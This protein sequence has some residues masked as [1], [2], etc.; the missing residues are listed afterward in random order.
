MHTD[1]Q[2]L[3]YFIYRLF[4]Q[5]QNDA[6]CPLIYYQFQNRVLVGIISGRNF[7][8]YEDNNDENVIDLHEDIYSHLE[9]IKNVAGSFITLL[10]VEI[11]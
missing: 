7:D 8:Y 1:I 5:L 4:F 2:I 6:G 10:E 9:F 3:R 11:F